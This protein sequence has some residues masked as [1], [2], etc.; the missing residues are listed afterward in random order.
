MGNNVFLSFSGGA[1][2]TGILYMLLEDP[3]VEHIHIHHLNILTYLYNWDCQWQAVCEIVNYVKVNFNTKITFTNSMIDYRFINRPR[4]GELTSVNVDSAMMVISEALKGN[5]F[6]Y[7]ANGCNIPTLETAHLNRKT[8]FITEEDGRFSLD[9]LSSWREWN[10]RS[11]IAPFK[12]YDVDPPRQVWPIST[13]SKKE[14]LNMMPSELRIKCWSCRKPEI[15]KK[16]G[17]WKACGRCRDCHDYIRE[18]LIHN[19]KK[20]DRDMIASLE[21]AKGV[22]DGI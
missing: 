19:A 16:F 11:F 15:D 1:D 18:G 22:Y 6:D 12:H 21:R 10:K 20:I 17:V 14:I 3:K 9:S 8:S 2:S 7:I 13:M 4:G 5:I